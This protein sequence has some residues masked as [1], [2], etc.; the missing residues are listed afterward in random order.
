MKYYISITNVLLYS[1]LFSSFSAFSQSGIVTKNA[2]ANLHIEPSSITNP[3]G[4]DGILVPRVQNFPVTNPTRLGQLVY[5]SGNA[6]LNDEFYYWD[7]SNWVPFTKV[8]NRDL[9][10]TIYAFDGQGYT[11]ASP[12]RT[13]NFSRFLKA[14]TDGFSVNNNEITVGKNGLYLISFTANTKKPLGANEQANFTYTILVNGTAASSVQTSIAAE[15]VSS[16]SAS[17]SFLKRLNAGDKLTASVNK[18][19]VG[20]TVTTLSNY[21]AFGINNLTL[22]FIQN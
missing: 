8:L 14:S 2:K 18:S 10:E 12:Q 22:Y 9:D 19:N 16:T 17:F 15:E 4:Q 7:G 1:A 6:T 13:I 20:S 21:E 5:L 3:T 11:G